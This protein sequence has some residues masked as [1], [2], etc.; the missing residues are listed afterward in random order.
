M[1]LG[2]AESGLAEGGLPRP[3][4]HQPQ[5]RDAALGLLTPA[6]RAALEALEREFR[7]LLDAPRP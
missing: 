7:E 4:E 5:D 2:M 1:R 3:N 6:R